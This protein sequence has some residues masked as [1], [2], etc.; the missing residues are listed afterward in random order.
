MQEYSITDSQTAIGDDDMVVAAR[1]QLKM[2]RVRQRLLLVLIAKDLADALIA[3]QDLLGVN[4]DC[5][6]IL[7]VQLVQSMPS[8]GLIHAGAT[9]AEACGRS[10]RSILTSVQQ[11]LH[12]SP[13]LR[14]DT[15]RFVQGREQQWQHHPPLRC[16]DYYLPLQVSGKLGP[17]EEPHK[18][19]PRPQ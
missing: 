18:H 10:M 19:R 11:S 16:V 2:S 17:V 14:T 7:L 6:P 9:K 8:S 15:R 4:S 12:H 1:K 3:I 13:M 5:L